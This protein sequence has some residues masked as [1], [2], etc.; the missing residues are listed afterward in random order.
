MFT[1]TPPTDLAPRGHRA[2]VSHQATLEEDVGIRGQTPQKHKTEE[3]MGSRPPQLDTQ[4][5]GAD[6]MAGRVGC[7][8]LFS[9]PF[10]CFF[11]FSCHTKRQIA[12]SQI[13]VSEAYTHH[14]DCVCLWAP[15]PSFPHSTYTLWN[16]E[17]SALPDPE[18][19][20]MGT[21]GQRPWANPPS[22]RIPTFC[23]SR[24]LYYLIRILNQ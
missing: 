23:P 4:C 15:P 6:Y 3:R 17:M 14:D 20:K 7:P 18:M 2:G 11:F 19:P 16:L 5:W 1:L 21:P 8:P 12:T 24:R 13:S 10:F 9:N 22:P